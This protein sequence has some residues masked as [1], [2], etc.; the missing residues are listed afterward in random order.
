MS[1]GVTLSDGELSLNAIFTKSGSQRKNFL[2]QVAAYRL[3]R[4]LGFHLVPVA[5]SFQLGEELGVVTVDP[6]NLISEHARREKQLG[7]GAWCPLTDQYNLM[8]VL[9]MLMGNEGRSLEDIRY[10]TMDWAV[11]LTGNKNVFG[12]QTFLPKYLKSAKVTL[13]K[14]MRRSLSSLSSDLLEQ[15]L[16]DLLSKRRRQAMLKRRDR[17]L[18]MAK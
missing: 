2:P 12:H 3:D 1:S 18:A 6:A 9:D 11:V 5:A 8:Y 15:E 17:I 10:R 14:S 13:S 4:L 7:G 16:G